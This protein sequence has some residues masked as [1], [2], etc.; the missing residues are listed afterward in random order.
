MRRTP[1]GRGHNYPFPPPVSVFTAAQQ[2]Q[3]AE[4]CAVRRLP[5]RAF[6]VTQVARSRDDF[7]SAGPAHHPATPLARA[8]GLGDELG[9]LEPGKWADMVAI[10]LGAVETQPVYDVASHLVFAA[11]RENVT[12]VWVAGRRLLH[13][14]RL[15]TLDERAILARVG[16]WREVVAAEAAVERGSGSE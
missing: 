6:R 15:V 8:F 4:E 9:S 10:D 2:Q 3:T 16:H 1:L 11:G 13:G 14:R 5:H 7:H 12:D